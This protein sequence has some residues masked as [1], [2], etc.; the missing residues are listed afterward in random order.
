MVFTNSLHCNLTQNLRQIIDIVAVKLQNIIKS[1]FD[2]CAMSHTRNVSPLKRVILVVDPDLS[3]E[4]CKTVE[5]TC[6]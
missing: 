2:A 5:G 6:F 4:A 1:I 3:A